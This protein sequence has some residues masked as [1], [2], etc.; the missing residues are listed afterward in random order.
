MSGGG[1][2]LHI[3]VYV[4]MWWNE[5]YVWQ[6]GFGNLGFQWNGNFEIQKLLDLTLTGGILKL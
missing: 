6:L 2:Q 5:V 4:F 1:R 3:F